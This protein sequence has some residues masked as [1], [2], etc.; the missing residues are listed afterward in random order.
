[1]IG[2]EKEQRQ[3][4]EEI[5]T[6]NVRAAVD[7]GNETRKLIR[8]LEVEIGLLKG[9]LRATDERITMLQAQIASLQA[10]VFRGGT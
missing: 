6:R 10:V 1:M 2:G 3:A 5:T 7:H 8:N 4:Y 9:V